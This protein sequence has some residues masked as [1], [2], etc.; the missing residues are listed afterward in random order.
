MA[1]LA[2]LPREHSYASAVLGVVIL[3][4]RP[5]VTR[6]DCDKTKW[7][8]ADILIPHKGQSLCYFDANSGWWAT[9]PSVWNLRSK[10]PTP[11]EKRPTSADFRLYNVS[12]VRDSE[13]SSVM[14]NI[15]LTTGFPTSHRWSAYVTP[16]SRKAGSKSDFFV[17][18]DK[19]QLQ[20]NKVCCYKVSL[21]ENF[22]L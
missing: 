13:K 6:M 12:T 8:I 2:F 21:C 18:L 10:W 5:S 11:F 4:V 3:S 14:T 7:C 1:G 17:F 16:E 20:S 22:Q 19:S 15:K 9:P